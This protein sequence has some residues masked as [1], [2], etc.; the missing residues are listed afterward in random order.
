MKHYYFEQKLK[1]NFEI[2]LIKFHLDFIESNHQ[3]I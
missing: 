1:S 3:V 2:Y